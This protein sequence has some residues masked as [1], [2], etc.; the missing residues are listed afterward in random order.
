MQLLFLFF[1]NTELQMSEKDCKK[2]I[3]K[4]PR[5]IGCNKQACTCFFKMFPEQDGKHIRAQSS[6]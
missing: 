4:R 3:K 5:V 6:T 1:V 2:R